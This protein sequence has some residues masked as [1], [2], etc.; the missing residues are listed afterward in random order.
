MVARLDFSKT[1][2]IIKNQAVNLRTNKRRMRQR[3]NSFIV[4]LLLIFRFSANAQEHAAPEAASIP[5]IQFIVHNL[6]KSFPG[7]DQPRYNPFLGRETAG[8]KS[9]KIFSLPARLGLYKPVLQLPSYAPKAFF[10]RLEWV[11][12]KHYSL[13]LHVRFGSLHEV[14]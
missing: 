6:G 1:R 3:K 11:L 12:E 14:D 8:K 2:P 7:S 4:V 13:P 9:L 5:E 10:C